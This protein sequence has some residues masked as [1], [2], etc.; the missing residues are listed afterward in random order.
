MKN[1]LMAVALS[2][3]LVLGFARNGAAMDSDFTSF[4]GVKEKQVREFSESGTNKLPSIVWTYFD[5][6]RADDWQTATN[7]AKRLDQIG[8]ILGTNTIVPALDGPVWQPISETV[9]VYRQFHDW[10]NG[11]LHRFGTNIISSIP[12]G[13]VYFG[14]TDPGRYIVS[15]LSESQSEGVPFFTLTQ[16]Q[17][18]D[19]RYLQYIRHIYGKKLYVPSDEDL[20]KAFRDYAADVGERIKAGK[21]KPGEDVQVTADGHTHIRGKVALMEIN[22]LLVK[23]ILEK[24]TTQ[25][26]YVE[27]SYP[28]DW[29]NPQLQPNGLIMR[30]NREPLARLDEAV[31]QKDLDYWKLLTTDA[32]GDWLSQGTPLRDVFSFCEKVYIWKDFADFKGNIAFVK[33]SEAQKT[34]SKL[35]S[36]IAGLYV[37]HAEHDQSLNDRLRMRESADLAFRQAIALCPYSPEAVYGYTRFLTSLKRSGDALL[38]AEMGSGIDPDDARL[39]GILKELR[40]ANMNKY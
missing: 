3:A 25:E 23:C 1:L 26:F 38:I 8:S 19:G 7:L 28:I 40:G 16:N 29:M 30:L 10:N 6:V 31:V 24:N 18:V 11:W 15:A 36:S 27:Q 39:Q 35:R 22:G 4:V 34:F 5:T 12:K 14:G 13:S 20:R 17:L 2:F 21:L 9:G 33:N 32:L 37:W